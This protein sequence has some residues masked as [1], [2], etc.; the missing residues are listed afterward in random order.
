MTFW[1]IIIILLQTCQFTVKFNYQT[2]HSK[3]LRINRSRCGKGQLRSSYFLF[4]EWN[5][6]PLD[7]TNSES[8]GIS[9]IISFKM[10]QHTFKNCAETP[11]RSAT[12]YGSNIPELKKDILYSVLA[13]S[14]HWYD[15]G[16]NSDWCCQTETSEVSLWEPLKNYHWNLFLRLSNAIF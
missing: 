15:K 16:V 8:V 14:S 12:S 7:I 5:E 11:S 2:R 9:P 10:V 1:T 6:I 13:I 4:K 3:D